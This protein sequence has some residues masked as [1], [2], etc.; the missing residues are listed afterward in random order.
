MITSSRLSR[1]IIS[2]ALL[3]LCAHPV[4]A[5]DRPGGAAPVERVISASGDA[6]VYVVPDEII[7]RLGIVTFAPELADAKRSS[8]DSARRLLAA[9][10]EFDID[11]KHIQADNVRVEIRYPNGGPAKGIEGFEITREFAVTLKDVTK[12]EALLDGALTNGANVLRG[13]EYRSTKL[14]EHRDRARA[15]AANAAREKARDLASALGMS[16]GMPRTI[17]EG[18][19][20]YY[21]GYFGSRYDNVSQNVFAQA[22]GGPADAGETVPLGQIGIRASVSVSFDL[23]PGGEEDVG[24][25]GD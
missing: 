23:L 2:A 14:R 1:L 13:V 12:L 20:H 17:N 5:Q 15:M 4:L 11:P 22:G 16:V 25:E 10:G 8:D 3:V 9:I 18:G 6:T 19:F 7:I 21:G 24:G